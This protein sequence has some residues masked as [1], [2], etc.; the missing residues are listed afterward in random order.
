MVIH[1]DVM[2]SKEKRIYFTSDKN[3]ED[4][5]LVILFSTTIIGMIR[6]HLR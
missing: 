5:L 6:R 2:I 4:Y 1:A 3:E